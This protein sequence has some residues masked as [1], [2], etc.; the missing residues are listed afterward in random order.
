MTSNAH[1]LY[2]IMSHIWTR[3]N[4]W[5]YCYVILLGYHPGSPRAHWS[6]SRNALSKSVTLCTTDGQ[7]ASLS[8]N[9][10]PIWG[11]R[12]DLYY[13]LTVAG[14]LCERT[15]LSFARVTVISSKS[16]Q[17]VQFTFY[18]LLNVCIYNTYKASVSLGSVQQ[19]MPHY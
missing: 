12:P 17:Y 15:V 18:M 1:A 10:A 11:L 2:S 8:W 4:R 16:C 13:C 7:S 14:A 3:S 6:L 5:L 9:K 19:I